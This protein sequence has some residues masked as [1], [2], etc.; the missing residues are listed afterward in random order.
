MIHDVDEVENRPY[1]VMEYVEGETLGDLI[2]RKEL[3]VDEIL[4]IVIQICEGLSKAHEK[5]V[6]HRDIKPANILI[7][8]DGRVRIVDFGLA[9]LR[10]GSKITIEGAMIGTVPYMSP[11][12]AEG[13]ELDQMSDIFSL[14]WCCTSLLLTGFLSRVALGRPS[15][16]RDCTVN[17]SRWHATGRGYRPACSESLIRFWRKDPKTAIRIWK[18]SWLI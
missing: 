2:A 5:L 3:S 1:I 6:L 9:K 16:I 8:R 7:D 10:D 12:Q 18:A 17:R 14:G 15:R 13:K 11:E 4:D